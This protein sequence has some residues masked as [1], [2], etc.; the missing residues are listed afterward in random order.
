VHA[1]AL[2]TRY[3]FLGNRPDG[4]I[5]IRC[6]THGGTPLITDRLAA[7]ALRLSELV[8]ISDRPRFSVR[9]IAR[10]AVLLAALFGFGA[11]AEAQTI[12]WTVNGIWADGGTVTGTF[13]FDVGLN[14]ITSVNL[15]TIG[16]TN[17]VTGG[18]ENDYTAIGEGPNGP[19]GFTAQPQSSALSLTI[20]TSS[21]LAVAGNATV[22]ASSTTESYGGSPFRTW[23]S[24]T[25]I[26]DYVYNTY[27]AA[28]NGHD[29]GFCSANSPCATLNYALSVTPARGTVSI[30]EGGL[31]RPIVVNKAVS[32]VGSDPKVAS[33]IVADTTV[34]VGCVG[35][36]P[37]NCFLANNGYAVEIAAGVNDR[38]VLTNLQLGAG[39]N[40]AGALKFSYGGTV[41]LS[42]NVYR[43]NATQTGPIIALYPNN[44]GTTQS[45]V[46][47]SNSD[48][49]F[50]NSGANAGAIEVKPNG[51]NSLKLHFNHVEVHNA[52]YGIRTDSSLLTDPSV[53]VA[54]AISESEMFSFTNAAVNAFSTAGT[55][56][57][58][59]TFDAVRILNATVAIKAN[60]PL[61]TVILT[62]STV[63]GNG[64]GVQVLNG[65]HV[66]TPQNNMIY[67]NG[68]DLSG[69]LSSAPPK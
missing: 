62:N 65:A 4:G 15:K 67:G 44:P 31:F 35:A 21:S 25:I 5:A 9:Y 49:G 58:N 38:I 69:S 20:S 2:I 50:N 30:V 12:K 66:Y 32:I 14:V 23:S 18:F 37:A 42:G 40:G 68:A 19:N 6:I 43:G 28:R 13:I 34:Q 41:Q 51:N 48:I 61:S 52:S 64:T 16:G 11:S 56:T 10:I 26:G 22:N 63:S 57:T 1:A 46:Y 3:K 53:S 59:A 29:V 55:G 8:R 7:I 47:F 60:G 33:Q 54:T 27:V 45:Q 36:L 39:N 24:G 17:E